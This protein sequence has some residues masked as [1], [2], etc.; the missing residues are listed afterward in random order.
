M[1]KYY[2]FNTIAN[3][4]NVYENLNSN[5]VRT[6][7]LE[8][9]NPFK[10]VDYLGRLMI[11][12]NREN[13]SIN[14]NFKDDKEDESE[15]NNKIEKLTLHR[16][17]RNIQD[18]KKL[19]D[20]KIN[21]ISSNFLVP[22][23]NNID[24]YSKPKGKSFVEKVESEQENNQNNFRNNFFNIRAWKKKIHSLS[25]D[26]YDKCL[27]LISCYQKND[28]LKIIDISKKYIQKKLSIEEIIKKMIE[29]DKM[30]FILMKKEGLK[31][32]FNLDGPNIFHKYDCF[33]KNKL[34]KIKD[35]YLT[36]LATFWKDFEF[37]Y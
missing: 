9:N 22:N 19:N 11:G 21:N 3:E 34:S 10:T 18:D 37:E 36:S 35:T 33:N 4:I 30:K 14:K 15:S 13:P 12:S 26:F 16:Y 5:D 1:N 24:L 25:F 32:L 6:F 2:Y 8:K 28:K 27:S 7:D 29:V 17:K 20:E 23:K 31:V